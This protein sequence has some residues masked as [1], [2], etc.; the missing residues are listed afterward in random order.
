V[1]GGNGPD[2]WFLKDARIYIKQDFLRISESSGKAV[3]EAGN[4][5]GKRVGSLGIFDMRSREKESCH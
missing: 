2:I 3:E 4:Q 1:S 5:D